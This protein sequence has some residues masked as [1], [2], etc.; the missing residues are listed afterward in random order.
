MEWEPGGLYQTYCP[1]DV[2]DYPFD[3]QTCDIVFS[4]WAYDSTQVGK[5]DVNTTTSFD[6]AKYTVKFLTF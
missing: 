2:F 4:E 1:V 5:S 6:V 3:T